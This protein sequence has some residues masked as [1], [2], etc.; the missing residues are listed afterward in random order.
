RL[1]TCAM[2]APERNPAGPPPRA[3]AAPHRSRK[4]AKIDP[5][6]EA[7]NRMFLDENRPSLSRDPAGGS[8]VLIDMDDLKSIND[9]EGHEEGD[10]AIWTVAAAIKKLIRGDDYVIRWG[11]D[12]FLGVLPA[13]DQKVAR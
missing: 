1:V 6:T 4:R 13:M 10:R 7:Y 8:I 2:E 3:L 5:L 11:G 9:R 12:E